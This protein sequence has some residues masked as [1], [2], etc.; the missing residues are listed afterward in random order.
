MT[1]P[2]DM[3]QS[4]DGLP[5]SVL[6]EC[7]QNGRVKAGDGCPLAVLGSAVEG[8]LFLRA[9]VRSPAYSAL[10]QPVATTASTT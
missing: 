4:P 8:L 3:P 5:A 1:P 2:S 7:V 9:A 10:S 6:L